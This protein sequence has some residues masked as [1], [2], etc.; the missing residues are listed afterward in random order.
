MISTNTNKEEDIH[1][2]RGTTLNM[3]RQISYHQQNF[4][5]E[6]ERSGREV[7]AVSRNAETYLIHSAWVKHKPDGLSF[8]CMRECNEAKNLLK[9]Y[10]INLQQFFVVGIV[11]VKQCFMALYFSAFFVSLFWCLFIDVIV[12]SSWCSC[13]RSNSSHF[14]VFLSTNTAAKWKNS[15]SVF[16]KYFFFFFVWL[17]ICHCCAMCICAVL[18]F[19]AIFVESHWIFAING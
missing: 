7:S 5:Y 14:H 19:V 1:I 6:D 8:L 12:G 11:Y 10:A 9:I 13:S 3:H 18:V 2:Y 15:E 16:F 4:E 17:S